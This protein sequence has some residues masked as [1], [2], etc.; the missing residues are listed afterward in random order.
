MNDFKIHLVCGRLLPDPALQ[1]S[2]QLNQSPE[3][4]HSSQIEMNTFHLNNYTQGTLKNISTGS[5][6]NYVMIAFQVDARFNGGED[7]ARFYYKDPGISRV[8]LSNQNLQFH[9]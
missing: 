8:W 1:I 6:P 2:R 9:Q 3:N 5:L 4:Y 7:F